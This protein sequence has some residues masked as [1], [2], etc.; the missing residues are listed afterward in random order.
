MPELEENDWIPAPAAPELREAQA[1][2]QALD[3]A[4]SATTSGSGPGGQEPAVEYLA[5]EG[6][7]V[8][9]GDIAVLIDGLF[10]DGLPDYP[11]L[12]A[13]TRDSLEGALGRFRDIDVVLVT[14]RHDDHFDPAAVAR[15]LEANP[16]AALIAPGDAVAAFPPD[17]LERYGERVQPLDLAPGSY[18]RLDQGGF[19][20]EALGL[21]HAEIGHLGYRIEL[22][23]MTVLHLGDAQPLP[24]DLAAFLEGRPE[25]DVAL[26]PHW[27]L[28]GS[29]GAAIVE[30]IG[31]HCTAAFHLEREG[32]DIVARLSE[33]VPPVAVLDEPGERLAEGC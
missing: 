8:T 30:A 11:V 31:A 22:P 14:H 18:I 10:G 6:V 25:P 19:A 17:Q 12:P 16:E 2:V 1:V 27:V 13:A 33:W 29:G 24:P 7:L 21:A 20:V 4:G 15:H 9:G 5:N 28:G 23:G 32:G 26:V 3:Q